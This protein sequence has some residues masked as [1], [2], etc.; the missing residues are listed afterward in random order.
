[1]RW[2]FH[3]FLGLVFHQKDSNYIHLIL[4]CLV[5]LSIWEHVNHVHLRL[6]EAL[7]E[8]H[9]AFDGDVGLQLCPVCCQDIQTFLFVPERPALGKILALSP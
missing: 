6:G 1:M 3:I 7:L 5:T 9:V 2:P 4:S 8:E